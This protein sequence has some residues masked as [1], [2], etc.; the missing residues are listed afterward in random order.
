MAEV[1]FLSQST[2]QGGSLSEQQ[3]K[4][5][6]LQQARGQSHL[7]LPPPKHSQSQSQSRYGDQQRD[8]QE[9][10]DVEH[11][12]KTRTVELNS[13]ADPHPKKVIP[14]KEHTARKEAEGF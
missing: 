11:E 4:L 5:N 1:G 10:Q 8:D 2:N 12:R 7:R 13:R 9:R 3:L 14:Y 6:K